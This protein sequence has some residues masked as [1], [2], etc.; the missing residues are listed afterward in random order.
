MIVSGGCE[1]MMN[2]GAVGKKENCC[3]NSWDDHILL[4]ETQSRAAFASSKCS[5]GPAR[6]NLKEFLCDLLRLNWH[7]VDYCSTY[8]FTSRYP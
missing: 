5:P 3:G 2:W 7:F 6:Y 8:P 1:T 4:V